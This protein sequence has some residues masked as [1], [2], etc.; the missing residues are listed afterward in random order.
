[1]SIFGSCTCQVQMAPPRIVGLGHVAR[2]A[3]P[4]VMELEKWNWRRLEPQHHHHDRQGPTDRPSARR[5]IRP[6]CLTALQGCTSNDR[7]HLR[8]RPAADFCFRASAPR[9]AFHG[10]VWLDTAQKAR[11]LNRGTCPHLAFCLGNAPYSSKR[12]VKRLIRRQVLAKPADP[13]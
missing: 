8:A 11:H 2:G 5:A 7:C 3:C 4:A 1:M 10:L 9:P 13:S 12:L 6:A